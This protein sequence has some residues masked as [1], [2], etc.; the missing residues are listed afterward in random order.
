MHDTAFHIGTLA[1]NIYADLRTD[2]ILEVGS[3]A[4]NGSLRDNA[5]PT[6][7][8]VGLDIEEGEGV[9]MVLEPGKAFPVDE[10]SFD[11]VMATSVFEHDPCFWMTFLE[12]CRAAKD[13]GY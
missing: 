3:Q 2:S 8:Y 9:D 6:T 13:G 12:L 5:L 10:G 11:L 4:F 7:R 1:M